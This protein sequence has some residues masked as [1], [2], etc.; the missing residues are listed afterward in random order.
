MFLILDT[1]TTGVKPTDRIVSICWSLYDGTG[2]ERSLSHHVIFP[3]GFTIPAE[4]AAIHGITTAKARKTGIPL[5]TALTGLLGEIASHKPWLYVGHNVAFDRPI[6]L[7]EY[8]RLRMEEN[9]STLPTFCTMKTATPICRLP[10]RGRGGYKWPKLAELHQYL[11]GKPH[12]GAHDAAADVRATAR[13]F[14]EL[15]RLGHD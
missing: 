14:F 1:E 13:C 5:S 2:R 7:N 10:Q 8:G 15:R 11:F 12:T 9:L 3:E 6:V 4:A